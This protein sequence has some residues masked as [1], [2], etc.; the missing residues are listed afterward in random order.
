MEN[1]DFIYEKPDYSTGFMLWKVTNLW[2]RE[3]KKALSPYDLT[4]SQFVLLAST[5]WL[6][7]NNNEVTQ[8]LLANFAKI[9][10]MTTSTVLKTLQSKGLINR[11]NHKKDTRAKVLM[12]TKA[13][14]EVVKPA[15][16]AVEEF[17]KRFFSAIN[18]AYPA[19]N[20]HLN[21]LLKY[22]EE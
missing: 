7:S 16:Q 2:Q 10:P 12:L 22:N 17:D 19:F 1:S 11:A 6:Q 15:I 20:A 4:H 14:L 9:D 13:G 18:S 8:I 5:H 21:I 3:I